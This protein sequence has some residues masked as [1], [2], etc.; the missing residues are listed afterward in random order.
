VGADG[1]G[2]FR[3][4]GALAAGSTTPAGV[5]DGRRLDGAELAAALRAEL[6]AALVAQGLFEDEAAAMVATWTRQ[7]F[8]SPGRRVLWI[9]PRPLVDS[10]LP[11]RVVPAPAA[12]VR[13]LV[14]RLEFLTPEVEAAVETALAGRRSDDPARRAAAE[15]WLA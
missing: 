13:V 9:V 1:R 10:T 12:L 2:R 3:A 4:L 7:W 6:A 5:T 14:G 15:E 11:L 8:R